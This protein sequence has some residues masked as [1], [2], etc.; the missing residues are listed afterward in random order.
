[1]RSCEA[2]VES[3]P[4]MKEA[5]DRDTALAIAVHHGEAGA[6]ERLID[7]FEPLLYRYARGMLPNSGDAQDVVQETMIR[8][9]RT[10]TS[11]YD[12]ERVR[13]L[14]LRPWLFKTARNLCLNRRRSKTRAGEQPVEVLER[15]TTLSKL[16]EPGGDLERQQDADRLHQALERLPAGAREL[17]VLRFLEEMS[18]A[19]IANLLGGTEA[20]L[21]GRVFRS[22]KQL[23][24]VLE[25]RGVNHAL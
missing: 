5:D 23:R 10:L 13:T 24:D 11:R 18:Y 19:E 2:P 14:A 16:A 9:H 3:D 15:E 22:L 6:L 4:E 1:M 7:K 20:S 12:S 17:V 25:K 21:R 8:A